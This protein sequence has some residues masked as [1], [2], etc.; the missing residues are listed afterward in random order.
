MLASKFELFFVKRNYN[1]DNKFI[2]QKF[3]LKEILNRELIQFLL[4]IVK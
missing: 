3:N 4:I 2:C 1:I